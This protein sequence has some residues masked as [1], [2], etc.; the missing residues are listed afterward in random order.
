MCLGPRW[1]LF[2]AAGVVVG[3]FLGLTLVPLVSFLFV[4]PFGF[5]FLVSCY[6]RCCFW[7]LL[8]G[9][10][11]S[12]C[13][14]CGLGYCCGLVAAKSSGLTLLPLLLLVAAAFLVT[15]VSGCC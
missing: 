12:R 3:C 8:C 14:C 15:A 10:L 11:D 1:G 2:T 6:C 4:L 9:G 13:Y 5:W 7:L